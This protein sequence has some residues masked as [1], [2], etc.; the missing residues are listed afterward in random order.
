[1]ICQLLLT[2]FILCSRASEEKKNQ[3]QML[4]RIY[5]TQT[6]NIPIKYNCKTSASLSDDLN[7]C[8][9]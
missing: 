8:K 3:I 2:T 6:N 4:N 5:N 7:N 1:M 9:I